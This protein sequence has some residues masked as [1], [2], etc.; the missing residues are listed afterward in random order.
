MNNKGNNGRT[1]LSWAAGRGYEKVIQILL[2]NG[3]VDV[4]K[5]DLHS[6]YQ[7]NSHMLIGYPLL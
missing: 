1:P 2:A 7:D 3:A 6:R 4:S 5:D